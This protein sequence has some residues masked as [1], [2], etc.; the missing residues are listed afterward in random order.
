MRT[1]KIS[2]DERL[3]YSAGTV[4][5]HLKI[6]NLETK[7]VLRKLEGHTG[8]IYSLDVRIIVNSKDWKLI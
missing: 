4:D 8:S 2:E 6:W 5:Q 7:Q 1:L 3:L